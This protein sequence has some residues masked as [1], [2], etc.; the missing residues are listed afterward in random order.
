LFKFDLPPSI[1][2]H[3]AMAL[4]RERPPIINQN[5]GRANRPFQQ[6]LQRLFVYLY[7]SPYESA[8]PP[9]NVRAHQRQPHRDIPTS[10]L[11]C[12]SIRDFS[13]LKYA[14]CRQSPTSKFDPSG[15]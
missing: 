6:P 7:D 8:S 2:Q 15:D 12:I 11:R 13:A 9:P 10:G 3:T 5:V 14:T 4:H 1:G